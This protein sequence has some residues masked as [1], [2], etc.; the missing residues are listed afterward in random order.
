MASPINWT[1]KASQPLVNPRHPEKESIEQLLKQAPYPSHIWVSTSGST[2]EKWVGLSF[3]ALFA[4][5]LAVNAHL[6]VTSSDQWIH[7]LP[8]FHVGGIGIW[9]RSY[10]GGQK[11]IKLE[12]WDPHAFQQMPGTLSAL[13]PTQIYDLVK[14]NLS[15]RPSLRAV[16]VGGGALAEPLKQQAE[17]LGWPLLV[18]YGL[19]ECGSQVATARYGCS[20]LHFLSHIKARI[21]DRGHLQLKSPSLLSA[22]ASIENN[23]MEF[24][25]P[26]EEGWFTTDDK[27]FIKGSTLDILGRTSDFIKIGGELV[28][29]N[30]L[31]ALLPDPDCV[32]VPVPDERLGHVIHLF[33]TQ[34]ATEEIVATF[35]AS[36]LPFERI[37][38]VHCVPFI[39]R[40]PLGKPLIKEMILV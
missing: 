12:K 32:L 21:N 40:S 5:A 22:Y 3:D 26:K 20:T 24:L 13:V 6:G 35:N 7:A 38:A 10:L 23:Q 39:P 2:K 34:S 17:A 18:S 29:L 28:S 19:T 30:R 31:Q 25:D 37:R 36:V 4:S 14:E 27:A 15:P 33:S 11:I 9:T 8:D 1:D 16:I